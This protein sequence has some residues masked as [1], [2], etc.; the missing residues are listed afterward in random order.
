VRGPGAEAGHHYFAAE[1]T[2]A[3]VEA[4]ARLAGGPLLRQRVAEAGQGLRQGRFA[5]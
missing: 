3:F 1:T 2:A 4:A 5:L